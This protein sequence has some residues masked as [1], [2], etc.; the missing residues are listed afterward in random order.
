[1]SPLLVALFDIAPITSTTS[2]PDRINPDV[3]K[4]VLH[5]VPM[6]PWLQLVHCV[7]SNCFPH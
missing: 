3:L 2:T 7:I 4:M 6:F 5:L 1:M